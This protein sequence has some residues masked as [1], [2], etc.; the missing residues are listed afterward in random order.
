MEKVLE[1]IGNKK[2]ISAF[3]RN[4]IRTFGQIATKLYKKAR[5]NQSKTEYLL[6]ECLKYS[7]SESTDIES[8]LNAYHGVRCEEIA[9]K[10]RKNIQVSAEFIAE[11][12]ALRRYDMKLN[13]YERAYEDCM[14]S[15]A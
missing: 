6:G 13:A 11:K 10:A 2:L 5:I 3:E 1:I 15:V 14:K 7:R 8:A 12:D 9:L 4:D